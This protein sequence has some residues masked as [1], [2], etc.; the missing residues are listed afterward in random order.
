M[1][2]FTSLAILFFALIGLLHL[3]RMAMHWTVV[4]NGMTVPLWAS[5]IGFLV[6]SILSIML[7]R[8]NRR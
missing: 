7:W 5:A 3:L 2:P 4:I 1:K 6:A 8:E